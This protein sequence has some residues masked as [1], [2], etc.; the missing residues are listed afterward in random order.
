MNGAGTERGVRNWARSPGTNGVEGGSS[1]ASP[2]CRGLDCCARSTVL[3]SNAIGTDELSDAADAGARTV[4]FVSS[5]QTG[6]TCEVES[7]PA[8]H[9]PEYGPVDHTDRVRPD[10]FYGTPGRFD[11][12]RNVRWWSSGRAFRSAR[13]SPS[14]SVHGPFRARVRSRRGSARRGHGR[15]ASELPHLRVGDRER[16]ERERPRRTVVESDRQITDPPGDHR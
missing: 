6:K 10:S 8:V 11:E 5:K 2:G 9:T 14:R 4:V 12:E 7:V 16:T 3:E 1:V 13:L 15:P